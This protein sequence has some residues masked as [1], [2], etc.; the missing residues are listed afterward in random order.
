MSD[1]TF[2]HSF[3]IPNPLVFS[4]RTGWGRNYGSYEFYQAQ[5][6]SGPK[7]LRGF[8][9]SRF[10]GDRRAYANAEVRYPLVTILTRTLPMTLGFNAFYDTGRV[11]LDGES[12]NIWHHGYGGGIW[13]APLNQAVLTIEIGSSVE[14]TRLYIRLGFLF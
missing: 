12:S 6:L 2:Y 10:L 4:L 13:V 14:E 3:Y 1:I 5:I 9:K 7:E 11:W 8:R